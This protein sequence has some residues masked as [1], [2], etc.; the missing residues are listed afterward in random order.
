MLGRTSLAA[1]AASAL[2]VSGGGLAYA[3]DGLPG[4]DSSLIEVHLQSEWDIN[5]LAADGFDL[6][7]YKRVED[8]SIVVAID[9]TPAEIGELKKRGFGIGRTIESPEHRAAVAAERDYQR[10]LDNRARG[11]AENGVPKSRS[12]VALPGETVIQRA[13]KFTNYAGTFLYVEAHN[14]AI[15][16][17]AGSNTQFTGPTLQMAYA[18][19]DGVYTPAAT[20][21]PRN[22]DIQPT[23]DEYMY[24]RQLI[25]LTGAA[26]NIPAAQ[27]TVRVAA[28]SGSVDTF[29]VTEWVGDTLPPHVAGY[30]KG[31]FN[32]YQDP[33]ENRAQLDKLATDFPN[34][35]TAVNLP[36]LT[37][38][39]QRKSQAILSGTGDIGTAPP[40]Q[41]GAPLVE[42]TGEITA[43]A[44]VASIPFDGTAGQRIF[45]TVDGIPGGTTDFIFTLKDPAGQ[46]IAGPIDTGTSPEFITHLNL[47]TTGTY[48]FEVSG[49][50]GALGDFTF[51][52]Q[53][54]TVSAAEA[55]AGAVVLTTKDWGHQGGDDVTAE[56]KNLGAENAPLSVAVTG[57]DIIVNLATDAS[58][59][60]TSTAAQVVAAINA[61]PAASA[62]VSAT[63]YRG[64]P[65]AGVVQPRAKVNLDDFLNAPDH[66]TRGPFQQRV[67]RIGSVRDGSKVGVF[68]YC[69][70]HAREWTT[71]LSCVETAERLVKNYATD[72]QTKTLMDNVE[73]F[74]VPNINP[75][76]GHYSMY[77]FHS[78][79]RNMTNHCPANTF[80]DPA[81]RDAWGVDLNRNNGE[82]SP[83]DGY[84]GADVG[85]CTSDLYPG[86]G[87]YSEPEIKNEK[88]VVDSFPNIKF[89][90]NIHSFGGYFMWAPGAYKDDGNRT[91]APAPNIGIEKYF[92][93]A[94]EKILARI[95]EHRGT[96]ILPQ[97]TGPIA[98]VLYS[99]AG[100][101]ADDQWYR[102]GVISYSFETGADR[103]VS[104]GGG[105]AQV[106]TGFQPCFAG[107]GT[108]GGSNPYFGYATCEDFP[109][110]INE[111]RD[112]AMEFASGNYGMVESAYD[113]AM[114][115]TP[116]KTSVEVSA[117][118]TGGDPVN[119]RFNWDDEAAVIYYTT[120]GSTPTLASAKYNNQRARSI[121]EVLQITK[122]GASEIKWFAVDIKGNQSAVQT[123]RV[124]VGANEETGTVSGTVPATLALS[125]GTAPA[126]EPFVPGVD[127]TYT[128]STNAKVT[129]TAGDATLTVTDPSPTHTGKLVNG[130]FALA[131]PLQGLGV[132]KTWTG[133][134]SNEDVPIEFKQTIGRTDPLRT[135]TYSK[136]L[137]FTLSTTNP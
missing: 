28:S 84:F 7:E 78:Q 105:L 117:T 22:I 42:S 124:L 101:S 130:A 123:K 25:R 115:T 13:D 62:L 103:F 121:G 24:N 114:D 66:V 83:F 59:A 11:Y 90:N 8:D 129:S 33:T 87:E 49:Y 50:Q 2:L 132:V 82:Y 94:G 61:S 65:G 96:V 120:D 15:K 136:T 31:F 63:T 79:R 108:Y 67:Y 40:A 27:M 73:V 68:L 81:A 17:V 135:G 93:E 5:E 89:A 48:R 102:K 29:K 52:V 1:L 107:P 133:P 88:W 20:A 41:Y 60:A 113:Y 127:M 39:Y 125:L 69:Q 72:P 4:G 131:Q 91:T 128:A 77:D 112:Q 111:G 126:F 32:R 38:G 45:A 85:V 16:R 58:G 21:M 119:F 43:A 54:V 19:P 99:A 14:K 75:D 109:E 51:K 86:P 34:L 35:V 70:Q 116:P 47:P 71:G 74:I 6:A 95:K 97:R 23:P 44:P 53:P 46:V 36:H 3:H 122:L 100:N 55:A 76:G 37:N 9:A 98:D 134:T 118:E 64:A 106:S 137:T 30:Q 80:S 110:L 104:V 56:I 57:K 92:F 26:A 10:E 12:A 18:G